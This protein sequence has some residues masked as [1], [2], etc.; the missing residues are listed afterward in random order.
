MGNRPHDTERHRW[1]APFRSKKVPPRN[2]TVAGSASSSIAASP[3]EDR[4]QR[5]P[6]SDATGISDLQRVRLSTVLSRQ[7]N[8]SMNWHDRSAADRSQTQLLSMLR[9][10]DTVSMGWFELRGK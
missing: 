1:L 6:H 8:D 5:L 10:R 3:R 7:G 9:P 4:S 2:W